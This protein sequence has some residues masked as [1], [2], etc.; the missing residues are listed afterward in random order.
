MNH[1]FTLNNAKGKK[2]FLPIVSVFKELQ[3][4]YTV[5]TEQMVTTKQQSGYYQGH[6]VDPT[7]YGYS[8]GQQQLYNP[9]VP[10]PHHGQQPGYHNQGVAHHQSQSNS[11]PPYPQSDPAAQMAHIPRG[12]GDDHPHYNPATGMPYNYTGS[13][14]THYPRQQV[15]HQYEPMPGPPNQPDPHSQ[16]QQNPS[17]N[18]INP[19]NLEEGSI[20]QYGDPPRSGIIK[21][22]GYL[23]EGANVLL[24]GIEMVNMYLVKIHS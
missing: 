22:I 10:P 21:W 12:G 3:E 9:Q 23:P 4:D 18:Q 5:K 8:P 16:Q 19:Y 24:A 13:K 7:G 20:I 1:Y 14:G 17:S 6:G 15:Q 2:V 11:Q